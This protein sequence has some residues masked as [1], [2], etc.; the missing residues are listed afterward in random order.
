MY[1]EEMKGIDP[2]QIPM[3]PFCLTFSEADNIMLLYN[4]F[5]KYTD[6][7]PDLYNSLPF[8]DQIASNGENWREM[9]NK[10]LPNQDTTL[11]CDTDDE[12]LVEQGY[13]LYSTTEYQ[14]SYNNSVLN[15]NLAC[16]GPFSGTHSNGTVAELL[17]I[18]TCGRLDK[19]NVKKS[20]CEENAFEFYSINDE[21]KLIIS[22]QHFNAIINKV[23]SD[24]STDTEN[25]KTR[26]RFYEYIISQI[27]KISFLLSQRTFQSNEHF[28][29]NE[30]VYGNFNL[31]MIYGALKMESCVV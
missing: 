11:F 18:V 14:H 8:E 6:G 3:T 2:T 23:H 12:D 9:F 31:L 27:N 10:M 29:C 21:N 4:P 7:R 1:G 16:C 19:I 30:N 5:S 26:L 20:P 22:P 17:Q 25:G 15:V 28:Y 24:Y 13:L